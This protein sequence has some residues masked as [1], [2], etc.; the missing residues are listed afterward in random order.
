MYARLIQHIYNIYLH[1]VLVKIVAEE[2]IGVHDYLTLYGLWLW[3]WLWLWWRRGRV[4]MLLGRLAAY[5][6]DIAAII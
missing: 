1:I 5:V 3:L 6:N 2:G 4:L